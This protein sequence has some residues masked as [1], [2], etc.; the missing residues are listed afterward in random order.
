M[1]LQHWN[2][3]TAVGI[4]AIA[5]GLLLSKV[6]SMLGRTVL[7]IGVIAVL[8]AIVGTSYYSKKKPMRCPHCGEIIT[9]VGRRYRGGIH[10]ID[11][12]D[13]IPCPHCGAAVSSDEYMKSEKEN[14]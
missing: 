14:V 1:K 3:I 12:L 5:G 8:S 4:A 7:L 13:I 6:N 11:A 9:P 10:R 2:T